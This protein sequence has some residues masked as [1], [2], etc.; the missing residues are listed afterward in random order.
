MSTESHHRTGYLGDDGTVDPAA[1]EINEIGC[2][3]WTKAT[4][5][6]TAVGYVHG[7]RVSVQNWVFEQT[8]H[9]T[10]PP[11]THLVMT[12]GN[13]LCVNP[14]H[15]YLAPKRTKPPVIITAAN[16]APRPSPS[17][18]D[19]KALLAL[20][21]RGVLSRRDRTD[22]TAYAN[23]TTKRE[24]ARRRG[25]QSHTIDR[26]I[27]VA[28]ERL[29]AAPQPESPRSTVA[30]LTDTELAEIAWA[31]PS[32]STQALAARL[33]R[34]YNTVVKARRS[35]RELGSWQTPIEWLP[36][37]VCGD[38]LARVKNGTRMVHARCAMRRQSEI[39]AAAP[40]KEGRMLST[41]YVQE[42][43]KK[44]PEAAAEHRERYKQKRREQWEHLSEEE[45][46]AD[47][48]EAHASDAI[49]QPLT[50][51]SATSSGAAWT[52]ADDQYVID[53]I[54]NAAHA[55]AL[56]LGRTLHAVRARRVILRER[57]LL[58]ERSRPKRPAR[59]A[60][61]S[62]RKRA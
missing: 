61:G 32:E 13:H 16:P 44:H 34:S 3:L 58:T 36:C 1:Y 33:N 52:D 51:A 55:V 21:I 50:A 29:L 60:K 49:N 41:P 43:R 45:R 54:H 8:R 24:I 47:L 38:Q 53:H 59:I 7:A 22:L 56:H 46:A 35:I 10:L 62:S 2:H 42:W 28:I 14:F 18:D 31:E 37:E 6:N 12:C 9:V 20:P 15:L 4:S 26:R 19:L 30:R 27:K 17:R 40:R 39:D 57:G 11:K 48:S 25:E 5:G 23:G